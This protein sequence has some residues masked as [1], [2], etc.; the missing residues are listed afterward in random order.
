MN[1]E[2][3]EQIAPVGWLFTELAH[4]HSAFITL[5]SSLFIH[6]SSLETSGRVK[7]LVID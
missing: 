4:A 2:W 1:D 5:H 6:H 3:R 7:I